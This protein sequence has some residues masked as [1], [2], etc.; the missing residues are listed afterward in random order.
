MHTIIS[1]GL[2][3]FYPITHCNLFSGKAQDILLR[4]SRLAHFQRH[5]VAKALVLINPTVLEMFHR[6]LVAKAL[7]L[8]NATVLEI[9]HQD[10]VAKA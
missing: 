5:L 2:Y 6:G 4:Q 8:V 3:I 7:V 1:R 9:F 10:L